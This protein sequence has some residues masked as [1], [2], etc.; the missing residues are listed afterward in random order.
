MLLVSKPHRESYCR[1]FHIAVVPL[2]RRTTAAATGSC[3][4]E[5]AS[6]LTYAAAVSFGHCMDCT[7][8]FSAFRCMQ[9]VI[10]AGICEFLGAVLLG[11][12]VADTIKS[13]IAKLPAFAGTPG[14]LSPWCCCMAH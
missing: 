1:T 13:G 8:I 6:H 9:A 7:R 11:S 10:V 12:N 3:F 5:L 2:V 4:L 14:M